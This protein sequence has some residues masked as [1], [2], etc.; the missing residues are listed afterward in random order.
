MDYAKLWK[1]LKEDLERWERQGGAD[2]PELFG[3]GDF[4]EVMQK[5]EEQSR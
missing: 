4:W 2:E 1:E 3:A 5:R